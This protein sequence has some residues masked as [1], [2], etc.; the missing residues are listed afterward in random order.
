M[1]NV[2]FEIVIEVVWEVCDIIIFVIIGEICEVIED[3]LNVL[4]GG[5][6]CVV[7]KLE[8]GSWYVN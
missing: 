5:Q 4:D 7:E 3:I 6:L 1:F 8:D 2:Q